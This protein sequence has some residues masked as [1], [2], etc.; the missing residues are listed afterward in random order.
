MKRDGLS[1]QVEIFH[2]GPQKC[3][4]TWLYRALLEHPEVVTSSRDSIHFFDIH[5]AKGLEWYHAHFTSKEAGVWLDPTCTYI[6]DVDALARIQNYNPEAKIMLTARHPIERAFSHYWHEKKKDRFNFQ[7]E[8][9]LSHYDLFASWVSPGMYGA[10]LE[11]LLERFPQEQIKVLW[12]DDLEENPEGFFMEVCRF[13]CVSSEF[14]PSV[15]DRRINA[16]G[17]FKSTRRR[18]FEKMGGKLLAEW[19]WKIPGLC[20]SSM[21]QET[22]EGVDVNVLGQLS[23]IF[24]ADMTRL[25]QQTGRDLAEWKGRYR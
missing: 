8:E 22:L 21:R 20:D 14:R 7:F 16:A 5:Y 11:R 9:V 19:L 1:N 25:E 17:A 10:A 24:E 4:T 6:R 18:R 3:G 12:F 2:I 13:C 15:M 23:D